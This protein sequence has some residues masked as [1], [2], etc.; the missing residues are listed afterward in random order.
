MTCCNGNCKQGRMCPRRN[1]RRD[2]IWAIVILL[3]ILG[4]VGHADFM[5]DV[6]NRYGNKCTGDLSVDGNSVICT[7]ENGQFVIGDLK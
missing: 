1:E 2:A 7:N 6:Q 5:H 4:V 3:V